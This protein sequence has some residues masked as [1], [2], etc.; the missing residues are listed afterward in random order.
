[1]HLVINSVHKTYGRTSVLNDV[2]FTVAPGKIT[3][4]LGPNG[5]GKTTTMKIASGC[6]LP[7]SGTALFDG[8]P[9]ADYPQPGRVAAFCL[10]PAKLYGGIS[11]H[12]TMRATAAFN[13]CDRSQVEAMIDRVGLSSV[14]RRK[15]SGLSMGMRQRLM[16]GTAL[17]GNPQVLVLDEPVNGLDIEG[18]SWVRQIMREH[19]KQG[20]SVLLSSHLLSEVQEVADHI[21]MISKGNIVHDAPLQNQYHADSYLVTTPMLPELVN[22]LELAG[23]KYAV[24]SQNTV[25]VWGEIDSI[26]D[27]LAENRIPVHR[28]VEATETDLHVLFNQVTQGEFQAA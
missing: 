26:A 2:S 24:A 19:C 9:L 1:M 21:V 14:A 18:V 20:G 5:S 23:F 8:R 10:E 6:V 15:V 16:I 22:V 3:A 11:V 25:T 28:M 12:R 4:F 13:G 17:L 27:L 7:T